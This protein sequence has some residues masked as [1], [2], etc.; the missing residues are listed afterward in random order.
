MAAGI[1]YLFTF[2]PLRETELAR[3][4]SHDVERVEVL[5]FCCAM[6]AFGAKLWRARAERAAFRKEL[7]PPWDGQTVP[8]EAT[9]AYLANLEQ[10]PRRLQQTLL[11]RRVAS[12]LHFLRSRGAATELD[13]HLRTLS[14][15]DVMAVEGSYALTR[16]ITWAIPILG[17]LGTVLGITGAISG[18]TPEKLEQD[19]SQV[20]DG[21]ALAFDATALGLALTMVSMFVNFLVERME[22]G[23]LEAVDEFADRQLAHR[24]ERPG[25]EGNELVGAVQRQTQTM[26]HAMEQLVQRQADMWATALAEVDRRRLDI[27]AGL[28]KRLIAALEA[29]MDK[30]LEAHTRRLAT[31]EKEA[32]ESG[33]EA[34]EQ[35]AAQARA[36]CEAGREQ[37]AALSKL[38]QGI[39]AHSQALARVQDG[40]KQLVHLQQTLTQNLT[41]LAGAGAF[42]QA[43]H[44]LT[45]AIHLLT[46]R[47]GPQW[48]GES[49]RPRPGAAA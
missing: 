6:A 2:G 13:D 44:S 37:Q 24:F 49:N 22:N 4:V 35:V 42:E 39:A 46:T 33:A 19:L 28:E 29:A 25:G 21:L 36:V 23:I 30:T 10:M 45:A 9:G 48:P 12:V 17:F 43:V 14:D 26:L 18:V 38:V 8:V 5:M 1:L 32:V 3:Y 27:E 34:M 11:I 20:T 16:F 40:E 41:T 47:W 7:L 31:L 15:N